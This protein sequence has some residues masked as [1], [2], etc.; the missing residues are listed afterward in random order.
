MKELVKLCVNTAD[1]LE[2]RLEVASHSPIWVIK[3]ELER[4]T[5]HAPDDQARHAAPPAAVAF[6]RASLAPL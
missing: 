2:L 5:G 3:E 4:E 6:I 1:G